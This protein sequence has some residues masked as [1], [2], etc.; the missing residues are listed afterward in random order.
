MKIHTF[1]LNYLLF[2]KS[3]HD[4]GKFIY[5][6][7]YSFTNTKETFDKQES[8]SSEDLNKTIKM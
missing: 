7:Y 5:T 1:T 6:L 3:N 4:Q 2:Y 8:F